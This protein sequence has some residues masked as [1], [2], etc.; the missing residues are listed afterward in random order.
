MPNISLASRRAACRNVLHRAMPLILA[1][2]TP[3]AAG[4]ARAEEPPPAGHSLFIAGQTVDTSITVDMKDRGPEL[5]G[6]P[7]RFVMQLDGPID[8]RRREAL[9]RAGVALGDY[10]PE[11]AYIVELDRA[12]GPALAGL[13]FVRWIGPFRS[14]W[15][16]DPQLN[17]RD[18][19]TPE[20]QAIADRGDLVVI[21]TLFAGERSGAVVKSIEAMAGAAVHLV[22]PVG[23]SETICATIPVEDVAR[24]ADLDE[25]QYVEEAP[26]PTLRN[27]TVRW[28]VQS[29]VVN[30]TPLH[31]HGLHGE[32]QIV[33][34]IDVK[35]DVN[36]CSF[37]DSAPIGPAHRKIVA[38][39]AGFGA[40]AHGTHVAGSVVGDDGAGGDNRGMAYMGRL[41]YDSVPSYP[42]TEADTYGL[43]VQ[44]HDQGARVHTNSWGD[45]GTTSYNALARAIDVYSHE[46]E[47]ALVLFA[48]TNTSNLRNPENA[49]NVLAVGAS[50]DAGLEHEHCY[51]GSGPTADGRRKPEI[52]APGCSIL[53]ARSSTACATRSYSGTSMATPAVAGT[54]ML[55]RQYFM[56]GYYPTGAAAAADAF[57]PSGALLKAVLLNAAVDMT[58]IAFYPS[59]GEGWGRLLA[60]DA[61]Y[62]A[63]DAR[64]LVVLDD[65][66]NAAG[67]SMGSTPVEYRIVV[68][69]GAQKLKV[70]L[71]WTEPPASASLG[72]GQAWINDLDI[73]VYTPSSQMYRGNG[74]NTFTGESILGMPRDY[75]NNVEQV[76]LS[77]P[78]PGVWTIK[79]TAPAVNVAAQGYALVATGGI[80]A[81]TDCNLNGAADVLD[82]AGGGSA[83][84]NADGVP[85]ECGLGGIGG[86]DYAVLAGCL[87]GP[88]GGMGGAACTCYDIDADGDVDMADF[89][90]FAL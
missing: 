51:G 18:Y 77:A 25:V 49:K 14:E 83:D 48:V 8:P 29:D 35:V 39:N 84:C 57:T 61:L 24:L 15:K 88:G 19:A 22:S 12:G 38:Y 71:A 59:N 78:A 4:A 73:E 80:A 34:I 85:D 13:S 47:D 10:L 23:G 26:E 11:H 76:H 52:F 62:F 31:D 5:A 60:D 50:G 55:V 81:F 56:D 30:A 44:H 72:T 69:D 54:A 7:G 6:Q 20:R 87:T 68:T 3:A 65:V 36:H 32:G 64:K 90:A 28:V 37:V 82:I 42:F 21:V 63:G 53:S 74:F 17:R 67:R 45:D 41:A 27:S 40:D 2:A 86:G 43:L 66:P 75:K 79:V 9:H 1:A 70:T 46:H 33:G 58:G 89:V 16:L